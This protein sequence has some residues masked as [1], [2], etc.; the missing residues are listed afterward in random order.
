MWFEILI[1]VTRINTGS[2]NNSFTGIC[3]VKGL[4]K[5]SKE[6]EPI[7]KELLLTADEAIPAVLRLLNARITGL[8]KRI[9]G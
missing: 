3:Q 7:A 9:Y 5:L 8:W 2:N 1:S 4:I 6:C